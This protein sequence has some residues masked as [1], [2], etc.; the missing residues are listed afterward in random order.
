MKPKITSLLPM[1]GNSERVPN[2]NLK[3]FNG[4]PL[5]RVVLNTLLKS[6]FIDNIVVNTDSIQI[7]EDIYNNYPEK[8]SVVKRP[9][10]L[11]GDY[12]SMNEIIKYDINNFPSDI[13]LQTHS[14]NPLI[15]TN[16]IDSALKKMISF[17]MNDQYDSIFSVTKTQKRFYKKDATPLNHNPKMLV[18]QHLEPIF[19]ENSCF[20][21]FTKKSFEDSSGRIG[22]NPCMFEINKIEAIDIDD[23]EDFYLAETL[24]REGI[25]IKHL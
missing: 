21:I 11:C 6:S 19:E 9:K 25:K 13:Y 3:S 18:T 12:I 7:E 1:K 8:V 17:K 16:T 15:E 23:P 20:F 14:T 24:H 22:N 4:S 2:K 10:K 5:Y